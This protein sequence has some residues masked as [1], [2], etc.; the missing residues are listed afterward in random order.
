M[1]LRYLV[2]ALLIATTASAN[3]A[4]IRVSQESA[5]GAGDFDTNILGLVT[6][7]DTALTASSYYNYNAP[8]AASYN[9][10][11]NGGPASVDELSQLFLVDAA[12]GLTLFILHDDSLGTDGGTA[13]TQFDLSGDTASIGV[14]DDGE[15]GYTDTGVSFS[16]S[17]NWIACCTDGYT[18]GSL[19]GSWSMLGQFT[20]APTGLSNWQVT[21]ADGT[22]QSLV[23]SEGRRVRL[24]MAI[25]V[26]EPGALALLGAGCLLGLGLTRRRRAA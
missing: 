4:L 20:S 9:G 22:N 1:K 2:A 23:L 8:N 24:D 21:S 18:I 13:N 14:R 17:H 3:A 7:F 5:A 10:E 6:S 12:D 25:A 16:A 15:P 26:P 19:D 11:L